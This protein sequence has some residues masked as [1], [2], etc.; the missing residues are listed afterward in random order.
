MKGVRYMRGNEKIVLK[1][2]LYVLAIIGLIFVIILFL[3]IWRIEQ[4][5]VTSTHYYTE[6][7]ILKEGGI[8]LNMHPLS[9]NKKIA[10]KHITELPFVEEVQI[11]YEFPNRLTVNVVE[12]QLLGYIQFHDS[13]LC[14][15]Q[16]GKVL[17]QSKSKRFEL[18]LLEGMQFEYFSI[19][20][21]IGIGNEEKVDTVKEM[22][23]ILSKYDF[24]KEID[25]IDVSNLEEIHL[26]VGKLNVIIG[27]IRNF[28]EKIKW[29]IQV[30]N[31]YSMGILD[32]SYIQDGQAVL[33]PLD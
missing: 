8:V 12:N 4:I 27:N 33:T 11:N 22:V 6:E 7:E 14:I 16:K 10:T 3:P 13:F 15:D 31:N 26:Y 32:L 25:V 9:L 28:D 21:K 2:G 30:N 5:D 20:E 29:L 18:P 24:L 17:E 19:G 23:T 1:K